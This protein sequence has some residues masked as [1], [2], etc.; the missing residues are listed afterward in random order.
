[1]AAGEYVSMR[2]QTELFER[3][4]ELER[5]ELA[6][7]PNVERVELSQIYQSRGIDPSTAEAMSAEVMADPD[8]A[9]EVHAREELGIDP[10]ALGSPIG[11]A[12]GSFAAFALG[13]SLPLIPWFITDGTTA[14]VA[15]V[16]LAVIGAA[17]LGA[18]IGVSTGRRVWWSAGRQ[19]L[20]AV[21]AAGVTYV[22]G[23][24]VGVTAG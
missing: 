19:V 13:A 14:V 10:S 9:L 23:S 16:I 1:M 2:A 11:A 7:N 3:E 5:I 8:R 12:V 15:S 6:R 21:I 17:G 24:L 18:G 20:V 4:L 22:V